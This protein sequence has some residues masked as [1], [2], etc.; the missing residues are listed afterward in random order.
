MKTIISAV[1]IAALIA[2]PAWAASKGAK[3]LPTPPQDPS[4]TG[5]YVDAGYGYGLFNQTQHTE[6]FPGLAPTT[7]GDS[8]DGGRGWLGR[9]GGGCDYQLTGDLSHW[10]V[11]AFG[12]Y[13]V[14]GLKGTDSLQNVGTGGGVGPP[15]IASEKEND[16]WYIGGRI[17][18]LVTPALL[19]YFD[20]GYTETTFGQQSLSVLAT[21]ASAGAFL[22][23]TTYHGWFAGGGLEYALNFSWLPIHGLFWRNEYRFASY[24]SKDPQVL[25][26]GALPG[27]AQHATP[28]VETI[29]SSIVWRF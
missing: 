19:S 3:A 21:G 27:Y 6:T 20:A 22:P 2:T 29:T 10:V 23:S 9:I 17:G 12:D 14:M 26:P 5:C 8:E 24:D 15:T 13:D 18:Y 4:W 16:A 28:Y 25:G 7:S 11:G 1:A